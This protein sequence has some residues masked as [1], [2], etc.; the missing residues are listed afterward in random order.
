[1]AHTGKKPY[2]SGT[3]KLVI[4]KKESNKSPAKS[5]HKKKK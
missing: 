3:G 2:R 4:P 1:M 5:S